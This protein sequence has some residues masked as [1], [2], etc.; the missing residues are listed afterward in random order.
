MNPRNHVVITL[1]T[2]CTS[3]YVPYLLVV[4]VPALDLALA[5]ALEVLLH[6]HLHADL[7]ALVGVQRAPS[8]QDLKQKDSDT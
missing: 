1:N 3:K 7:V 4:A 6:L 5:A 8:Q 2:H